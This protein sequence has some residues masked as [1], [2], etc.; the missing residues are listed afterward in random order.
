MC[1]TPT[2]IVCRCG[3]HVARR[4]HGVSPPLTKLSTDCCRQRLDVLSV[5]LAVQLS[6]KDNQV[7]IHAVH[8]IGRAVYQVA[9]P[10][11]A[12]TQVID[13]ASKVRKPIQGIQLL[14]VGVYSVDNLLD[15]EHNVVAV[16]LLVLCDCSDR[17]TNS[18][19]NG[20]GLRQDCLDHSRL[21]VEH[22]S[23]AFTLGHVLSNCGA[24]Q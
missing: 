22:H 9:N 15:L 4:C 10:I 8:G 7:L 23:A 14:E 16:V 20:V 19:R 5:G 3:I 17:A 11:N 12:A 21:V 1:L 6:L 24:N 2:G 18:Y 13:A